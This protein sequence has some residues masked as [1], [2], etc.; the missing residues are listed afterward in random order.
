MK[1]RTKKILIALIGIFII[2]FLGVRYYYSS[3]NENYKFGEI[4]QLP[5][6][7]KEDYLEDFQYTYDTLKQY[8]PYFEINK[9]VNGVDWLS[10]YEEYKKM[11]GSSKNDNEF[12][13]NMNSIMLELNNDHSNIIAK[14]EGLTFA[15]VYSYL[16]KSYWQ[17]DI[18]NLFK[19][20]NVQ[21]RYEITNDKMKDHVDFGDYEEDGEKLKNL[22]LGIFGDNIGYFS[23]RQMETPFEDSEIYNEDMKNLKKFLKD[24]KD[25]K[26]IVIDIRGNG[27]GH[28]GYW[29]DFLLPEII[30]KDYN[31]KE[32]LFTKDGKLLKKVNSYFEDIDFDLLKDFPKETLDIVRD[33]DKFYSGENVVVPNED[34]IKF[35]GNIYLLVDEGVYSS[36][37][38]LATFAKESGLAKLVGERTGG[39]GIGDD[40]FVI[41][42]PN[43]GYLVRFSKELGVTGKGSIN[44]KDQTT[45]D[46]EVEDVTMRRTIKD[47]I[48]ELNG[49]KVLEKVLE[50]EKE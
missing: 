6:F 11:V 15:K 50:L 9:E 44:E 23:I 48:V 4:E 7:S 28:S 20:K 30:G 16:P 33:F 19:N 35:K 18:F 3:T 39:D 14:D 42:L 34:S 45:P 49:D 27:G 29:S 17:S 2:V 26:S 40:P 21:A 25:F 32:Y 13:E 31:T 1:S 8:Y 24:N 38:K 46:Y 41:A 10:N 12:F 36:S 47:N 22:E 37:E 5:K 43:T